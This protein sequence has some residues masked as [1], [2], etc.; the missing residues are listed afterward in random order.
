MMFV[1]FA[2]NM[3]LPFIPLTL[4]FEDVNYYVDTPVVMIYNLKKNLFFMIALSVTIHI[5]LEG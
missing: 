2:G 5:C 3:V 4:S 1:V